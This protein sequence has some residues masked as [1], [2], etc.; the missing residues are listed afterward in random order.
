MNLA[1]SFNKA[2]LDYALVMLTSFCENNRENNHIY[3]LHSELEESDFRYLES[4]LSAYEA[5]IVSVDVRKYSW[6]FDDLPATR[7]WS[8]EIYY[9]L[10]LPDIMPDNVDRIIY[11]DVDIV[12]HKSL[13]EFYYQDFNGNDLVACGDAN[14]EVRMLEDYT[15]IQQK[16]VKDI[17]YSGYRYFNSGVLLINIA[18]MRGQYGFDF[19]L[20]IMKKWD[21]VM[22]AP[23]QDLLNYA[24]FGKV[25]FVPSEKYN[26]YAR[27]AYKA[28]MKYEEMM[29]KNSI[30]HFAGDKPWDWVN[31]HYEL[32]RVWWEYAA[33][34]PIYE[35]LM[36]SYVESAMT[37]ERLENEA[38]RL[39]KERVQL[40]DALKEANS[41]LKKF[42]GFNN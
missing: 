41:V 17:W 23:D 6:N 7:M 9:R 24:H 33:L 25:K 39:C 37:E 32:E 35:K 18:Q 40:A 31:T 20:D 15:L 27:I 2:Y 16:W 3:I 26:L 10:I 38:I 34:T 30:I 13:E 11:L 19:Y 22:S 28:G 5:D 8:K 1:L 14:D 12:V 36:E 21:F 29:E 42:E 4:A